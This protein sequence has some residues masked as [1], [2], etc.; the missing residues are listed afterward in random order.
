MTTLGSS[1]NRS[2]RI[3]LATLT[4]IWVISCKGESKAKPEPAAPIGAAGSAVPVGSAATPDPSH[5]Q[6]IE[7]THDKMELAREMDEAAKDQTKGD[8]NDNDWV[9]AEFKQGMA[10]WKD[11]GVY[12]DG[13]PIAFLTWGELP[14]ALKPTWVK[15]KV[16]ARKRP[17]T[18]DPGWRWAKQR[19]Y[20]F[21]DYLRALGVSPG[22]VRE[23]HVY[24][25][26]LSQ[27]IIATGRD[28]TSKLGD[29]FM[30]RFGT[31]TGGKPIPQ[32][33][34]G[35]GNGKTPD[36]IAGVMIYIKKKP[37][38]MVKNEGLELDG[39]MQ[40]GVPYYGDPIRGG[41]RVYLD[42]KL[43]AIIKRQELKPTEATKRADGSL[44]WK[45]VDVI[46]AMCVS[47]EPKAC[48]KLGAKLN[49]VSELWVIRDDVR[50]RQDV[51][52]GSELATLTFTA[53][54]QAKGGVLLSDKKIRANAIALHTRPLKDDEIP[55]V[56]PDDE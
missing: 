52:A 44:A 42:D 45:L 35:F 21:N 47:P 56:T 15:D 37:P 12:L 27:T 24:G 50:I 9:P 41:I 17:H 54:A 5:P 38:T 36:K 10:R 11:V 51:I 33:P 2:M 39:K 30:F 28:L 18:D 48:E 25:P 16:S 26:K 31:N 13:Q 3:L 32:V 40:E 14:I 49:K 34:E 46:K 22:S 23:I 53:S 55:V 8:K 43:A 4:L 19:F 29:G 7:T 1:V 20:K 6:P